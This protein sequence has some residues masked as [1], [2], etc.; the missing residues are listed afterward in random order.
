MAASDLKVK[1]RAFI[2][3]L[4]GFDPESAPMFYSVP[5]AGVKCYTFDY[6]PALRKMVERWEREHE[7]QEE[8]EELVA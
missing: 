8:E 3:E 5:C 4:G 2:R 6:R 7:D 1:D